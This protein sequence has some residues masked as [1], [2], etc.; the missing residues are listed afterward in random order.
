MMPTEDAVAV[1]EELGR[2]FG[3]PAWQFALS[4]TDANRFALRMTRQVLDDVPS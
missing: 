2:R 4:A 3:V 1:G